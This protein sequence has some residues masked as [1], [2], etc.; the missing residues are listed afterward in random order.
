MKE[1]KKKKTNWKLL[2]GFMI[3]GLYSFQVIV[4]QISNWLDFSSWAS[5]GQ[6][7]FLVF[8]IVLF[9]FGIIKM[10]KENGK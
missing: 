2:I 7:T 8:G 1:N 4:G 10:R 3:I 6:S 9:I 5:A